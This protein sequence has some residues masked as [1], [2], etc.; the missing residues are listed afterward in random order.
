MVLTLFFYSLLLCIES[1]LLCP[2]LTYPILVMLTLNAA[3]LLTLA[4]ESLQST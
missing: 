4:P 3:Q 2:F 1:E